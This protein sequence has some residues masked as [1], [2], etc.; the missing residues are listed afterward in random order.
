MCAIILAKKE[1]SL[2]ENTPN[3]QLSTV[4]DGYQP[5]WVALTKCPNC[6]HF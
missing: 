6:G 2:M 5:A 1:D 4:G 3:D